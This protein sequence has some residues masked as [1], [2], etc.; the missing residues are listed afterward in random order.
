MS[1]GDSS[2]S[3]GADHTDPKVKQ[4]TGSNYYKETFEQRCAKWQTV[5]TPKEVPFDVAT[6]Q[7][8]KMSVQVLEACSPISVTIQLIDDE[9]KVVNTFK[10]FKQRPGGQRHFFDTT[11]LSPSKVY[12]VLMTA[13]GGTE[14]QDGFLPRGVGDVYI[15]QPVAICPY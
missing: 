12:K 13:E 7:S 10:I 2:D 8:T 15:E 3:Q 9:A 14:C 4:F 6:P 11:A 5:C 1:E